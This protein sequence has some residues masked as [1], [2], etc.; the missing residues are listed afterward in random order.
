MKKMLKNSKFTLGAGFL[1]AGLLVGYFAHVAVA[2]GIPASTPMTYAGLLEKADGTPRTG[3][4]AIDF[5]RLRRCD[6][7]Q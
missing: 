2:G 3:S 5:R 4:C 6:G 1:L 7:R